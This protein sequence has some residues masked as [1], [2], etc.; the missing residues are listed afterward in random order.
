M[1]ESPVTG[2]KDQYQELETRLAAAQDPAAREAVKR[3]IIA[4]FKRVDGA[5]AELGQLKDGIRGLADRYKQMNNA[6][7]GAAA[8]PAP[9]SPEPDRRCRPITWGPRL[10]SR[11]AGA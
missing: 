3:D 8:G 1:S 10:S 9:S 6:A 11:R 2:L 4:L 5:L 7:G